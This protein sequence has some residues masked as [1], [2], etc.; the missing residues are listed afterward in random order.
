MA[1]QRWLLS[2]RGRVARFYDDDNAYAS[3]VVQAAVSSV[4]CIH[5]AE[6]KLDTHRV[7]ACRESLCTVMVLSMVGVC[8]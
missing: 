3:A 2:P 4:A 7:E 8:H 1:M 5:H 6:V